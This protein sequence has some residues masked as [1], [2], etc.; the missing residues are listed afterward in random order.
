MAAARSIAP[1][2]SARLYS[3]FDEVLLAERG[4]VVGEPFAEAE[5]AAL[6]STRG[7]IAE[8]AVANLRLPAERN[9]ARRLG[10]DE[11][12]RRIDEYVRAGKLTMTDDEELEQQLEEIEQLS[13]WLARVVG[14]YVRWHRGRAYSG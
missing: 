8:L 5:K 2:V 7:L 4:A 13:P 6:G 12:V 11:A 1:T 14:R 9:F 3:R 10:H